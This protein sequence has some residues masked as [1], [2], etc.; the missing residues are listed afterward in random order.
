MAIISMYE[1]SIYVKMNI[2]CGTDE[3]F[4]SGQNA[5]KNAITQ[6]E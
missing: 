1:G 5:I 6:V 2:T 4:I 3:E